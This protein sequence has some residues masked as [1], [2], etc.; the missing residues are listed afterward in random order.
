M[1][2]VNQ[3]P[4]L[5]QVLA[6]RLYDAAFEAGR[7]EGF[8]EGVDAVAA[9]QE[10]IH[11][12]MYDEGAKDANHFGSALFTAAACVALHE[13]FGFGAKRL[14]RVCEKIRDYLVSELT[15]TRLIRRCAEFG[16]KIDYADEL[17]GWEES[18]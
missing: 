4:K 2:Q 13:M 14:N 3:M 15:P 9:K 7:A 11:R 6:G 16:I 18:A 12:R 8:R 1:N 10:E 17:D 5:V